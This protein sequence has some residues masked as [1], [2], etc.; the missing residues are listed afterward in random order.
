[1]REPSAQS[2]R[3][4]DVDRSAAGSVT[5]ST[6]LD[7]KDRDGIS[8]P[9]RPGDF[10]LGN[11]FEFP[12]QTVEAVLPLSATNSRSSTTPISG[13][14]G[15]NPNLPDYSDFIIVK[16]PG[17]GVDRGVLSVSGSLGRGLRDGKGECVRVR[18]RGRSADDRGTRACRPGARAADPGEQIAA[19]QAIKRSLSPAERKLDSRLAV[20]LAPR[21][22]EAGMTEVDIAPDGPDVGL[23][24]AAARARRERPLRLAAQR[25]RARRGPGAQ[26]DARSRAGARSARRRR[27]ATH[28]API[29]RSARPRR[30]APRA[31]G[32]AARRRRG[33]LRGRR[34]HGADIARAPRPRD[35][36][37][38]EAVRALATASTRSP[39]RRPRA[40]CP[41]STCCRARPA[42]ATR[43]RRCSRSCTTSRP[44]AEL[45]F[46]TAFTS[47]AAVR[48]QHPRAALR[49]RLR[50]DRRRHPLLQREPVPGRPDRAG[51][52]RR[53]RRRRAVL[54]L[55]RQRGQH[56]RRHLGQLRERLPRLRPRGRQVRRRGARL[57]SRPGRAGLRADLRRRQRRRR[58]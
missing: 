44:G 42:T 2:R 45:G 20:D 41:P 18:W 39:P 9:V 30:S 57:R 47:D 34:T 29:G 11:P 26:A 37:R 53:H 35:R 15:R 23:D 28:A 48:R 27:R 21:P 7:V 54:Q 12:Y 24:R 5:S 50:R 31:R 52:Q 32:R 49:R 33:R 43:A 36:H 8:V 17:F 51:G 58:W 56:A 40:S 19:L 3:F 4:H 16:V 1:M 10:G 14:P 6:S 46:A 38:H 22:P 25:R 13:R 55:R